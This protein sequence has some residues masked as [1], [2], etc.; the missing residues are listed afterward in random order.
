MDSEQIG[1]N[2]KIARVRKNMTIQ[3]LA[4]KAGM[5]VTTISRLERGIGKARMFSI[6]KIADALEVD[7]KTLI[8]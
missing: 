8:E 2:V 5:S 1:M 7:V 6:T 3:E 4:K